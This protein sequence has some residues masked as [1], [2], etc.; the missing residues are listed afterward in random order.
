[1]DMNPHYNKS[2]SASR[3][4]L[5]HLFLT[6]QKDKKIQKRHQSKE[7]PQEETK[8]DESNQLVLSIIQK[9]FKNYY[10]RRSLLK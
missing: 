8:L 9:T 3:S 6:E 2:R 7:L 4:S 10:Q 1:M 5:T